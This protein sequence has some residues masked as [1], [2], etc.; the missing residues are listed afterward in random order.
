MNGNKL[1]FAASATILALTLT[2]NVYIARLYSPENISLLGA[3]FFIT[4]PS[5]LFIAILYYLV[6][7][8]QL[9]SYLATRKS[10]LERLRQQEKANFEHIYSTWQASRRIR[11]DARHMALLFTEYLHSGQ[12]DEIRRIL[13]EL[14]QRTG[15]AS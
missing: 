1:F 13:L 9:H 3:R 11:H 5:L 15:N 12:Y 4:M 8:Q 6:R 7:Q 14:K 10:Y 2:T